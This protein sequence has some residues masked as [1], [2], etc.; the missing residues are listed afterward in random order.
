ML[1]NCYRTMILPELN[2]IKILVCSFFFI[3]GKHSPPDCQAVWELRYLIL[4]LTCVGWKALY[5][6]FALQVLTM[7]VV[8]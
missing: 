5:I 3:F 2:A 1:M 8:W 7:F 4:Q 6:I